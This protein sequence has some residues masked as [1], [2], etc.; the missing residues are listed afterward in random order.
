MQFQRNADAQ[1]TRASLHTPDRTQRLVVKICRPTE[2][3]DQLYQSIKVL[4][5]RI[6]DE[7]QLH[8]PRDYL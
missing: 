6:I 1:Q 3:A 5:E 8:H 2:S 7:R 4:L